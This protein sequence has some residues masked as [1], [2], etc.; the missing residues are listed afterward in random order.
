M[1]PKDYFFKKF[2]SDL[3]SSEVI[4]VTYLLDHMLESQL[5][6]LQQ[7]K[8]KNETKIAE[9]LTVDSESD[10][11]MEYMWQREGLQTVKDVL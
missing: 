5:D 8:Q 11:I 3:G 2:Q 7:F 10:K 6:F 1:P 9:Y 4:R